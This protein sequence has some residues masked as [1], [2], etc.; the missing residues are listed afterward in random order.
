MKLKKIIKHVRVDRPD[1]FRLADRDPADT[2]GI[3]TDVDKEKARQHLAEDIER[4]AD[5]VRKRVLER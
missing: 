1:K 3:E 5:V 4:L 2:H